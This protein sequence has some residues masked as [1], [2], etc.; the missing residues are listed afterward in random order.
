LIDSIKFYSRFSVGA[1]ANF[2]AFGIFFPRCWCFSGAVFL[3]FF[4]SGAS[5]GAVFFQKSK[6]PNP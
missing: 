6:T 2:G 5:F 4:G 1:G 3:I